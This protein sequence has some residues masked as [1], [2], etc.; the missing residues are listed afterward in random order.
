MNDIG[1]IWRR[2]RYGLIGLVFIVAGSIA[3]INIGL[4]FFV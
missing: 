4:R 1:E 2:R 3:A